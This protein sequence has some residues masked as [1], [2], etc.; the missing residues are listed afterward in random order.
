M[1]V[2]NFIDE[3]ELRKAI[4]QFHPEG[5]LFEVRIIGSAK[6][7]KPLSGYFKD[8]DSLLEALKYVDL[9]GTN[10]YFTLQQI[11]SA[12]FSRQQSN[13]FVAGA[14]STQDHEV[15]GYKWLFI[16]LDPDRPTGISSTKEELQKSFDLAK[17]V[18][19][20]LK[21]YGFEEPVKGVSGNGAHLLYRINLKN[22]DENERLVEKC[23]KALSM[24][25]DTESVK[26]DTSNFNPS[27]VA[28][29]YGSLAQKGSNTEERPYR[30]SKIIGNVSD[31]KITDRS[32]LEKLA[33]ELP[34]EE[35]R[36][37]QYNNYKPDAFDIE[38]WMRKYGLRY[39]AASYMGGTKY[40][41][42]ECPFDPSHKAPDSMITKSASGAL[43]FKCFHNHC[44]NYHWKELRLKFEPDAYEYTDN[45]KRIE[46][47]WAQHNRDKAKVEVIP[48][49]RVD[50][51]SPIWQTVEMIL[52]REEPEP[53]YIKTGINQIDK[54]LCGLEKG[55]LSIIS[56]LRAAAKSTLLSE[57]MLNAVENEH[58]VL[59]YSGEL[60]D[61]SFVNWMFLQA[62][63]KG[64]IKPS[65][66]Y[67]NGYYVNY[68]I[69]QMI[70]KWM[71]TKLWLFNN[72][73]SNKPSYLLSNI[74]QKC[75]ETK[76]DLVIID[77]LMALDV[78]EMNKANEYD[79]QTKF[80]WQLKKLAQECNVHI[81]LVA[82]PR[83][84]FG[85][86]RLEDVSGS[87]NIVNIIDN[88]FIIHRNNAD[89]KDKA[90]NILKATGNDWMIGEGSHVT[91][92]VEI[93]KDREHGTCDLFID[94][95]YEPES[96]RLKNFQS[97]NI[98]YSWNDDF[99]DAAQEEIPF[100]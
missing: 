62:A 94:L 97:E 24:L 1:A 69:K 32:Y 42:D 87:N 68:E 90:K 76:A 28:K 47:G 25:F 66:K 6:N 2:K 31:V 51:D 59:A 100:D 11:S 43:G 20:F 5:E 17:R 33:A 22:T 4:L 48:A 78:Q 37:T 27:R 54:Y 35:P 64:N 53:E 21:N 72:V 58:I 3:I 50:D 16:D 86:L 44:Q 10:I 82:H 85:F 67:P 93:A 29:L 49:Y 12:L 98:V 30:F 79:A 91:N 56:G 74:K 88:A 45:D 63:G 99:V 61:K 83:K 60:S 89:F 81:I 15:M 41:L 92:V 36:P 57:M 38:E 80:M 40:I 34:Q 26:V 7:K 52:N 70:A 14:N 77:N 9:R 96:K 39:T 8:V 71:S 95:Y 18:Y 13:R 23:L 46:E 73:K 19:G 65:A 84:A 55:K 75:I